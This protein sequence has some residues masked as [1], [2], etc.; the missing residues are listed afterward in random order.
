MVIGLLLT[1]MARTMG[2][3]FALPMRY[4]KKWA[5]ENIWTVWS[6]V[7]LILIAWLLAL[8]T[9]PHLTSVY[10]AAGAKALLLPSVFGLLWGVSSF[11]FGLGVDLAGM[12]LIFAMVNGLSSAIGSGVP[13]VI[14][15]PGRILTTGGVIVSLGVLGVVGGVAVCSW[16]GHIRWRQINPANPRRQSLDFWRALAVVIGSGLLAPC[17]NLGFVFGQSISSAAVTAGGFACDF[18]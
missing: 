16:A 4:M 12:S 2:G 15:H 14:Q 10:R 5:W 13:M 1:L 17:L 18:D 9:V 6:L 3:S 7:A 11:F 8:A